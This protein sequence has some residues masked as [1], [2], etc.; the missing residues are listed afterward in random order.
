MGFLKQFSL[1]TKMLMLC[2]FISTV[3]M[4]IGTMAY[5]GLNRVEDTYDVI[6]DDIMPKLED[7]NEMFV[8][9]RRIR[10][11]LR[12]LGLPGITG[13]QTAEAIRAA[14]E[15]IAAFEEAE[16]RYT[17]H[18]FTAGQKDL[19]EKVHADW[20]AFKDV[21][22]HVLAL[23][24]VG[25]PESMQQIVKIFFGACPAAAAKFTAS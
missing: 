8:R 5:Q 19:Y 25:T 23:Q 9:Y 22:T 3:S 24:K 12:T 20:V 11:T 6:T 16:K 1:K 15:S 21:G 14:N 7:A 10:I 17:G 13:E 2:L 4:V 18:G